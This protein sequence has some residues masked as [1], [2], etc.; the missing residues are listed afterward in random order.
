MLHFKIGNIIKTKIGKFD[1]NL[2]FEQEIMTTNPASF[3]YLKVI[4]K[5]KL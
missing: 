1:A 3:L 5:F 4:Y 2:G